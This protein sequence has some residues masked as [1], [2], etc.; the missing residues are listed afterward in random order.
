MSEYCENCY[1][2]QAQYDKV[3]EQNRAL[4]AELREKTAECKE[5]KRKY[6][7]L[8]K[9]FKKIETI[10]YRLG[11]YLQV[12]VKGDS[13]FSKQELDLHRYYNAFDK[14]V[15][16]CNK[17]KEELNLRQKI[18]DEIKNLITDNDNYFTKEIL[19]IISRAKEGEL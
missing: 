11:N 13:V 10:Y 19:D 14:S 4:Q 18:L 16:E 7:K 3:V 6:G 17:L 9:E 2:L 15:R 5:L 12:D 1:K 8:E